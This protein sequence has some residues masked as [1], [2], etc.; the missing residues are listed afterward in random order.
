M[1]NPFSLN[2]RRYL[3]TGAA[4]GIGRAA[5]VALSQMGA[6]VLLVDINEEGILETGKLCLNQ[7]NYLNLDLSKI[8]NNSIGDNV[9]NF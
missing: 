6:N 7:V 9:G 3:I 8:E 5:A 1:N 4:S 2:N